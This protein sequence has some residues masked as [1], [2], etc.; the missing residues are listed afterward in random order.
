MGK[1]VPAVNKENGTAKHAEH[2]ND[3]GEDRVN[4][5]S[6]RIIGHALTVLHALGIGCLE[7]I[8]ENALVHELHNYGL[9]ISQQNPMVVRYDG[10][11]FGEYIVDLLVEHIVLAL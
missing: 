6:N 10:I 8:Y 5:L 9:A 1:A 7:K 2:A 11:V 3:T 4:L